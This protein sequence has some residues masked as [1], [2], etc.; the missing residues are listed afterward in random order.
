MK[1]LLWLSSDLKVLLKRVLNI[2]LGELLFRQFCRRFHNLRGN[3]DIKFLVIYIIYLTNFNMF[4]FN[5]CYNFSM[6]VYN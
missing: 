6:Y 3:T 4:F 5:I 1:E 2:F